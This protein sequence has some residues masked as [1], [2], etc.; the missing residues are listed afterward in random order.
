MSFPNIPDVDAA[1]TIPRGGT[2]SLLLAS[3]A[4]EELGLAHIMNAEAEKLQYV[5]G[6]IEGQVL[7]ETPPTIAE[8]LM[9]NCSV[10]KTLRNV[11][12][13]EILLEFTLED[14]LK[15]AVDG[16]DIPVEAGSAWSVGTPFGQGNAQYFTLGCRETEKTVVLGLGNNNI[17]VGSIK[18]SLAGSIMSVTVSTTDPYM[19][20]LI[21]LYIGDTV[22]PSSAPGAFPYKYPETDPSGFFTTHTFDIDVSGLSGNPF[23][24]SVHAQIFLQG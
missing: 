6:T 24:L 9:T 13:K 22:P 1:I 11:I 15:I 10:N 14:I 8:V 7:P 4:F 20:N 19:M 23:Y 12:K 17:P 16:G 3:V 18:V 21:H 2:V 5:L